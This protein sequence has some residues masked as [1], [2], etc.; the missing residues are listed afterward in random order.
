MPATYSNRLRKHWLDSVF[1]KTPY[2][3]VAGGDLDDLYV[4]A[5]SSLPDA[6]GVGGVELPAINAYARV[7]IVNDA[8][9]WPA[10]S[11]G[12]NL[13]A[14]GAAITFPTVTTAAWGT[15]AGL[16]VYEAPSVNNIALFCVE[17]SETEVAVGQAL[18][19]PPSSLVARLSSNTFSFA[20]LKHWFDSVLGL[21]GALTINA[22][23]TFKL[24]RTLPNQANSG[25]VELS[26]SGYAAVS[27]ANNT[28]NF[29]LAPLGGPKTNGTAIQ[30]PQ[31]TADWLP[32]AGIAIY[33]G[34]D[35]IASIPR[36]QMVHSG[37]KLTINPGDLQLTIS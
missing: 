32:I 34:S 27:V 37:Q 11:L 7:A 4:A 33:S 13:K 20:L 1:S 14:N 5:M 9:A 10:Q 6:D 29:P 35:L 23:L 21:A 22:N 25:G 2:I 19:L 8:T 31:A 26:G 12:A 30:F 15:I 17:R 24:M 36:P 3:D 28:T 16:V 18:T